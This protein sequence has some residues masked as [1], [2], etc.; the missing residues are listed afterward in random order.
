METSFVWQ[1]IFMQTWVSHKRESLPFAVAAAKS[2][3]LS[4]RFS[5]LSYRVQLCVIFV[6]TKCVVF[7]ISSLEYLKGSKQR[8]QRVADVEL[9]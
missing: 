8:R 3:A 5:F 7:W 9:Y 2:I 4:S 1:D 6:S